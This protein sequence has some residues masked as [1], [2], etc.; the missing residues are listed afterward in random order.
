MDHRK[1]ISLKWG[2]HLA[3]RGVSVSKRFSGNSNESKFLFWA[4]MTNFFKV[5]QRNVKIT[6]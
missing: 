3:L 5:S 6:I 4:I 2:K 1:I